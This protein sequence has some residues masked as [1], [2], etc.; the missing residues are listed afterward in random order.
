MTGNMREV[1]TITGVTGLCFTHNSRTLDPAT[2]IASIFAQTFNPFYI[3][4][5]SYNLKPLV[6]NGA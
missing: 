2:K 1:G 5:S 6:T 3:V 4:Y